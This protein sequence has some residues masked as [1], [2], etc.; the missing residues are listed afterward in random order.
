MLTILGYASAVIV[1]MAVLS[2]TLLGLVYGYQVD[3]QVANENSKIWENS[4]NELDDRYIYVEFSSPQLMLITSWSSS[5]APVLIGFLMRLWY[6]EAS[7]D[8]MEAS[9]KTAPE[10]LATPFQL[11]LMISMCTG[12]LAELIS[13]TEYLLWTKKAKRPPV[14]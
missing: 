10:N 5:F 1:L 9:Q 7:K 13:Y 14:S 6:I 11:S 8:I 12:A 2:A 3:P 4:S